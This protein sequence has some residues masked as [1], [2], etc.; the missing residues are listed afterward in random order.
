MLSVKSMVRS[1]FVVGGAAVLLASGA[2]AAVAAPAVF[3]ATG[4]TLVAPTTTGSISLSWGAAPWQNRTCT[5]SG[6]AAA[7]TANAAGQGSFN[8]LQFPQ[9]NLLCTDGLG[10]AFQT[11]ITASGSALANVNAGSYSLTSPRLVV[12][13]P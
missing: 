5:S 6:A 7:S 13:D 2:S 11:I 10:A 12:R 8:D 3:S 1:A 9:G 4:G